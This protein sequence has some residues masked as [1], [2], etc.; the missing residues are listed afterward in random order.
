VLNLKS[1]LTPRRKAILNIIVAEYIKTAMPVASETILRNYQIGVSSATIRND[2]AFLE[3]EGYIARPHTSAGCSPL[4]KG[5]RHYVESL[6]KT[7]A[8]PLE[9]QHLIRDS[10]SNVEEVERWLKLAAA[11]MSRLVGN[12]AL[13]TF[14]KA[15][16]Y[17]LKHLEL[18][19]LNEFLV[20]LVLVLSETMLK[21][22]LL[23]FSEPLNQDQLSTIAARLNS[24]YAGL[25]SAEIAARRVNISP[26]EQRITE[27]ITDNMVAEDKTEYH[28]SYLEGLRLM[29]G[30]PE[31]IKKDRML[32]I[33][34][35]M[36]ARDWLESLLH[37][38]MGQEQVQ[39]VIGEESHDDSLKDLSLVLGCY[40]VPKKIRGTVGV[41]GPTRMDYGKAISTVNYMSGILSCL[42]AGVCDE[43]RK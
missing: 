37:K 6:S 39:I 33:L 7:I 20:L 17:R 15:S 28:E 4:A 1:S 34:E 13:V 16:Q 41:I 19:S 12:A 30:Q 29:L 2:M 35:I 25:T 24:Q 3:K 31:F 27:A 22:K 18:I 23:S 5:Y 9:E 43:D 21:Q 42:V 10:F 40:G 38:Q 26:V 36:E 32:G 11:I 14:P 8:L